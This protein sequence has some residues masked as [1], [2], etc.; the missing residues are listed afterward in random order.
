MNVDE[1]RILL[2]DDHQLM[3]EGVRRMLTEQPGLR[4]VGEAASSPA[5]L[6]QVRVAKPNVVVMD[7]HLPGE[8]GIEISERILREFPGTKIVVLS[9]DTDLAT[10]QRALQSGV[11]A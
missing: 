3:R 7:I 1:I 6:D 9:A 11:S 2:V 4:V 5:A 10:V 8:N